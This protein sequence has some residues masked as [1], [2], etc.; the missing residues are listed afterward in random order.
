MGPRMKAARMLAP[1][2]G[3]IGKQGLVE[4][5]RKLAS[6]PDEGRLE[7]LIERLCQSSISIDTKGSGGSGVVISS[8]GRD[9]LIL[10]AR[11]VIEPAFR[12]KKAKSI[13]LRNDGISAKARRLLIAPRGID[14]AI[15][16]TD[17]RLGPAVP[18]CPHPPRLG[19][20]VIVIGAGMGIDNSVSMGIVS[21][22][23]EEKAGRLT[24]DIIQTDA[25]VNLG[26]SG[27]GVFRAAT[28][29]LIGIV[30]YKLI[31]GGERL[32]E[33]G[34]AISVSI[35]ER[36]PLDGWKVFELE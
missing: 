3:F 28:G 21:K 4:E 8:E 26:N 1:E 31:V 11:H 19:C 13:E 12:S 16:E 17:G 7:R 27:G 2:G 15:V 24:Y 29:E 30:S 20:G 6:G 10:T 9:A 5:L 25:M 18:L 22:R 32:A 33:G 23:M 34:F 14:A 36:A 35:L